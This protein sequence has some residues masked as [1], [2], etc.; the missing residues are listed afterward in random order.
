ME[1]YRLSALIALAVLTT[2][3]VGTTLPVLAAESAPQRT[4]PPTPSS[5]T[6]KARVYEH[7]IRRFVLTVPPG[8]ALGARGEDPQLSIR[9]NKGYMVSVQ[10][11]PRRPRIP[12]NDMPALLE[13]EYLGPGRPWSVRGSSGP[14]Q[15]AGL[16]AF[17]ATYRG[18]N[19][20]ARV[21]IARGSRSD[22]VFMFFA[23]ENQYRK[24]EHEFEWILENFEPAAE[25]LRPLTT[26]AVTPAP[27]GA[28]QRFSEPGYGYTIDYPADW[29]LTKPSRVTTVFSGRPGTAAFEAVISVQNVQPPAAADARQ[30]ASIALQEVKSAVQQ[31]AG[32]PSFTQEQSWVSE[33]DAGAHE[34]RQLTVRYRHRGQIFLKHIVVVP[35]R[36][37][38][39][40]HVWT[41][42]AP[43]TRF[44]TFRPIASKMLRSW[45]ILTDGG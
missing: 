32:E 14:S 29:L 9:S 39:V 2:A 38:T 7:P 16:P 35:R 4:E 24:L 10:S 19:T 34:G 15:V 31:A 17:E 13:R 3:A 1:P 5:K 27:P 11:G 6:L 28:L 22:F 30:A 36:S 8:A 33:S 45:T 42:T 18:A 40:A 26:A 43:E 20:R 37:G 23:P 21:V 25:D 41:Y 44:S 12:L